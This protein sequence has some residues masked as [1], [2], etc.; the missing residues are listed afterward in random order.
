MSY[1]II[2]KRLPQSKFN[3]KAPYAMTPEYVT[4][5]NT[6]NTASARNE[7]TYHNNN[8]DQVSYHVA[9]DDIEAIQLISFDRNAWHAGKILPE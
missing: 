5:H 7:A 9:I 6:G 1:K 4:V 8:N 2:D 3:I